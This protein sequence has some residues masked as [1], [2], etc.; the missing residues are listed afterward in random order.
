MEN[1]QKKLIIGASICLGVGLLFNLISNFLV[2][3]YWPL[4]ITTLVLGIILC[5]RKKV[6]HGSLFIAGSLVLPGIIFM[7]NLA[8]GAAAISNEMKKQG[9][10]PEKFSQQMNEAQQSLKK[11]QNQLNNM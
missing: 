7:I 4:Y 11:A 1:S 2:F 8:I 10:T 5:T 3:I 9:F 6:L